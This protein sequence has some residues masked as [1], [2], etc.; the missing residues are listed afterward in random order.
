MAYR[1]KDSATY[2]VTFDAG[3]T[4][5]PLSVSLQYDNLVRRGS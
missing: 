5:I 2:A 3:N 4:T 1:C